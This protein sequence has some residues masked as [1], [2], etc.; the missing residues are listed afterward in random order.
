MEKNK[1]IKKFLKY[2]NDNF[3]EIRSQV[4]KDTIYPIMNCSIHGVTKHAVYNDI[5]I[6]LE[7]VKERR[8]G[9]KAMQERYGKNKKG[10]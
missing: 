10:K 6:C 5:S 2:M 4:A 7:C 1:V 3:D 8:F 9:N